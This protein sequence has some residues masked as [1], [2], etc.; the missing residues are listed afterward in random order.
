MA[1]IEGGEHV[2]VYREVQRFRQPV[3]WIFLAGISLLMWYM[4]VQQIVLGIPFGNNPAPDWMLIL[5]V[6]AFGVGFPA[7]FAAFA[8][9]V[10]VTKEALRFRFYPAR[11]AYRTVPLSE[12]ASAHAETYHPLREFGGWGWRFGL[13]AVAYTISGNRG[14]RVTLKN[15]KVFLLGS[16]HADELER[17]LQRR[18]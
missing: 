10:L 14:V 11:L 8:L 4:L 15:G 12:I 18:R 16:Q 3:L 2:L 7:F 5:L 6:A 17:A 1:G 9:E 13:R